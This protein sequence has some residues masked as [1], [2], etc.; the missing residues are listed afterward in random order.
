MATVN[1]KP[2]LILTTNSIFVG[3][4]KAIST[5][6]PDQFEVIDWQTVLDQCK[7]TGQD[8]TDL[9]PECWASLRDKSRSH[10]IVIPRR[11]NDHLLPDG[12]G[13]RLHD[14]GIPHRVVQTPISDDLVASLPA[15]RSAITGEIEEPDDTPPEEHFPI[16][17]EDGY[18]G[19]FGDIAKDIAPGTEA[20]KAAVYLQTLV[21]F[22]NAIGRGAHWKINSDRHG[23]N[24]FA[25]VVGK[26][27]KAKKGTSLSIAE[28][29]IQTMDPDAPLRSKGGIQSGEGIIYAIRDDSPDMPGIPDKRLMLVESEFARIL[30]VSNRQGNSLASELRN[31][32][33]SK[34]MSNIA[35]TYGE[36]VC[37]DPHVSLI[38]HITRFELAERFNPLDIVN[39]FGNRILW[40]AARREQILSD[41]LDCQPIIDGYAT[42]LKGI[43][44]RA[45]GIGKL[46]WADAETKAFYDQAYRNELE[47]ENGETALAAL[48]SRGAPHVIRI[49]LILAAADGTKGINLQQLKAALA[50]WRFCQASAVWAFS[51]G[52]GTNLDE[53]ERVQK[54]LDDAP[55]GLSRSHISKVVLRN[56]RS[57]DQIEEILN[58]LR[59]RGTAKSTKVPPAP[60]GKKPTEWWE[61]LR[62][63]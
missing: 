36:T 16:L 8:G 7:E 55:E 47:A 28:S 3:L 32:W 1:K 17:G 25:V 23:T 21:L 31:A 12:V 33:D 39:G 46:Y 54:A 26:S 13:K 20:S 43:L 48:V 30:T 11:P 63:D 5:R 29:I 57:R 58:S 6:E 45:K 42:R 27:A 51:G 44:E 61:S 50:I 40:V 9:S 18:H 60:G 22:G 62:R 2:F 56:N 38:G 52:G 49:A 15:F 37:R 19:I 41:P 59:M 24:E 10:E 53:I 14:K 34:A 35:K 4:A